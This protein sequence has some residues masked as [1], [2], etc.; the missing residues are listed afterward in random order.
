MTEA[1][2][3][4]ENTTFSV[5]S[6]ILFYGPP[7]FGGERS[8]FF[9]GRPAFCH[10]A[11]RPGRSGAFAMIQAKPDPALRALGFCLHSAPSSLAVR[12]SAPSFLSRCEAARTLGR[13]RYDSGKTRSRLAGSGLLLSLRSKLPRCPLLRAQLFVTL[14]LGALS[15]SG[16]S[17]GRFAA[18]RSPSLQSIR[19]GAPK[20]AL[21]SSPQTPRRRSGSGR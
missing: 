16:W 21:S 20:L 7:P 4:P 18:L 14:A 17:P 19:A 9:G 12:F 13:F 2:P 1:T 3:S 11:K 6:K 5:F 8:C 15:G 10:A